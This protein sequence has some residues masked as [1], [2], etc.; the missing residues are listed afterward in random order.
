MKNNRCLQEY[1]NRGVLVAAHRG[2]AG[3][4]IPF[5]TLAAFEVALQQ[6]ADIIETDVVRSLDGEMF[7]FHPN[8]EK[9]HLN[10][11]IKLTKMTSDEIKKVRY[12]NFDRN[13]TEC[14][15][16][17]LDE[18]LEYLK[19]RCLINLDH[20]WRGWFKDM[21]EVVRRHNMVDQVLIKTPSEMEYL[22]MV[23]ELAPDF[24]YMPVIQEKDECSE[25]IEKM[26]INYV[27]AELVFATE[28]AEVAQ[29][30]YIEKLKSKGY[31]LWANAILYSYKVQL[32]GGHTDNV[33][34]TGNPEHGWGWLID[35][36]FD[37]I[38]TDWPMMLKDFI[39]KRNK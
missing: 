34:V 37:V 31:F 22:K 29:P 20:G 3:G 32:S 10:Q 19:G 26:D 8:Q 5:N 16:P 30:E 11:D 18:T 12:V 13:I 15:I 4:D 23:E 1:L 25:I 33:A 36:G 24:M 6:G 14:P 35:R 28:Q 39:R 9:N 2:V 21:I 17:T 38:Q 7:I 27:G